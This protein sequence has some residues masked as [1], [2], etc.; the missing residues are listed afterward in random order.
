VHIK[1]IDLRHAIFTARYFLREEHKIVRTANWQGDQSPFD[2]LEH[3]NLT[4]ECPMEDT[5]QGAMLYCQ[6]LLPWADEH[7]EERVSGIPYNPPPSH[8]KWLKK[9]EDYLESDSKFSHTYPERMWSK[10]LH[11]GLRHDIA[12]LSDAV[13]L[14]KQDLY[15]RQCYIPIYFPED[16]T[17]AKENRRIP[18]TLGWHMIV[19]DEKLHCHYPMR[20][21]DAIRHFHNDLYLANRLVLWFIEQLDYG[22]EAGQL[23]FSATSFHCFTND[24]YTLQKIIERG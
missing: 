11:G 6:P 22:L 8:T 19:R 5:K 18:C 4:L 23:L 20:S 1:G 17:A 2:F 12:D 15:T 9:T 16:L 3:L 21:C 10:G 7:F 14:L 24:S 13:D